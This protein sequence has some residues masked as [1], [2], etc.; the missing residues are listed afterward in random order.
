MNSKRILVV[1]PDPIVLQTL[2]RTLNTAGYEVLASEDGAGA[3]STARQYQPHLILLEDQYPR[4]P[5]G[6]VVW[7][8]ALILTWLRRFE[9]TRWIPVILTCA[10]V[11]ETALKRARAAGFFAL[12]PKPI[13]LGGLLQVIEQRLSPPEEETVPS[14]G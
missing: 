4:V 2:V 11:S 7:D 9:E 3:V 6:G 5:Y 1:D 13:D 8:G 14:L 12:F 10:N